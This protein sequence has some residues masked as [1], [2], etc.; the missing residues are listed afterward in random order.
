M[1]FNS[2]H[3]LSDSQVSGSSGLVLLQAASCLCVVWG[4][5]APC[6]LGWVQAG[7]IAATGICSSLGN[8]KKLLERQMRALNTCYD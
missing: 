5:S 8:G 4:R 7:A 3:L 1:A 2:E 6:V